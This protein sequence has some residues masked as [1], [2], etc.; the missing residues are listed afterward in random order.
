MAIEYL[1]VDQAISRAGLRMVAVSGIPR[2]MPPR[3]SCTSRSWIGSPC[4]SPMTTMR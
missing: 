3:A 4:A 2:A 1:E